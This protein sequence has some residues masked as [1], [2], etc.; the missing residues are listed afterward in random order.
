VNGEKGAAAGGPSATSSAQRLDL[1]RRQLGQ[2]TGQI[3]ARL[4]A[5]L[6]EVAEPS[7]SQSLQTMALAMDMAVG[8][9]M[10][11]KLSDGIEDRI[12]ILAQLAS[13]AVAQLGNV[14]AQRCPFAGFAGVRLQGRGRRSERAFK[15]PRSGCTYPEADRRPREVWCGWCDGV[16]LLMPTPERGPGTTRLLAQFLL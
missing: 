1:R 3:E 2:I 10:R 12:G 16:L 13:I 6:S 5:M 8:R 11:G 7:P 4:A 15:R 14:P 9:R